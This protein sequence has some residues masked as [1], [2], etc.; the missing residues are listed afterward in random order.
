MSKVYDLTK[1][2]GWPRDLPIAALLRDVAAEARREALEEAA[3][4]VE[5]DHD[6]RLLASRIRGLKG[7]R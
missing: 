1:T 6:F 3:S 4:M 7:E 5:T 2:G